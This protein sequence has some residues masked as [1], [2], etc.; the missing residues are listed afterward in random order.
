M[1]EKNLDEED[2]QTYDSIRNH[3]PKKGWLGKYIEYSDGLEACPRFRFFS[4][5]C[6]LGAALNNKVW[7]QRG[8]E[9]LL[10]KLFPN[11]WIVLLA[12]PGRG[13]KTSTINMAVNCLTKACEG[14]RILADKITPEAIVNALSIPKTSKET[15][16]IG[17]RDATGLI[18]APELSV[19]FGKQTYNTG[20]VSLITDL[21]D[22]REVWK[23]E[24]IGRGRDTLKNNCISILGGSTP[25][26]LQQMLPQD[27]F[28]GGFMSR[29]VLVEMPSSYYKRVAHPKRPKQSEWKNLIKLLA[30]FKSL[31]GV[32]GWGEGSKE[33]YEEYYNKFKP[34]G[35]PQL[36][37]YRERETE[38]VLKLAVLLDI[39]EG[40]TELTVKGLTG[41]VNIIRSLEE[42]ISPR[43]ERLST[44]PRMHM[45]QEIQDLLRMYGSLEENILLSKVY[46]FLTLGEGQ[47]YE[48][49]SI[50]RKSKVI[51]FIGKPGSYIYSLAKPERKDDKLGGGEGPD[52]T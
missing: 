45:T 32:I 42:E 33:Y 2:L 41:S 31:K 13:H 20:L 37:A 46:R 15:I 7:I 52:N 36:D 24:T 19:F 34:V 51:S 38:Q 39:N 44:N 6:V 22:Y 18:K 27:A 17:P 12:P 4:A 40:R 1:V 9:G 14:V 21:Y 23:G 26:W 16:R 10:P 49:L 29:F 28:T 25:Q 50:L 47:F 43:I 11:I 5:C 3:L 48:A 35:D 8:D 30:E